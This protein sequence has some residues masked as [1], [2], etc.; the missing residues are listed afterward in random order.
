ML[1]GLLIVIIGFTIW[2]PPFADV[3][4]PLLVAMAPRTQIT[5]NVVQ[6]QAAIPFSITSGTII[7]IGIMMVLW[8]FFH[9]DK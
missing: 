1:L 5:S 4:A 7:V 6:I 9:K 2:L 8:G 3:L